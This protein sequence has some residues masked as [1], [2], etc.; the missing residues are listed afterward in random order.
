MLLKML[1]IASCFCFII[2]IQQISQISASVSREE[3]FYYEPFGD[4]Q[5]LETLPT[6]ESTSLE[7]FFKKATY[8]HHM[9]KRRQ[10]EAY[11]LENL[12]PGNKLHF[13]RYISYLY[14][15]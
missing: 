11:N 6:H 10:N 8:P 15:L 9:R 13:A 5:P 2:S 3:T 7:D 4:S 14:K 12:L 1:K